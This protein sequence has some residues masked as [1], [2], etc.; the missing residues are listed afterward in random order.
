MCFVSWSARI[1]SCYLRYESRISIPICIPV[2]FPACGSQI[3]ETKLRLKE[4]RRSFF[5]VVWKSMTPSP[6]NV[7]LK[8]GLPTLTIRESFF[9]FYIFHIF[10]PEHACDCGSL[11]RIR[12][13]TNG[14]TITKS[15]TTAPPTPSLTFRGWVLTGERRPRQLEAG[16]FEPGELMTPDK[17]PLFDT[18]LWIRIRSERVHSLTQCCGSGSGTFCRIRIRI[19]NKLFRIRIRPIPNFSVKKSHFLNQMHKKSE[20]L[21][22]IYIVRPTRMC[23]KHPPTWA[24]V[25]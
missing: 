17:S 20:Y 22:H 12:T 13:E 3:Q 2:P 11:N 10:C 14:N 6:L 18:V 21:A 5:F 15:A 9:P 16:T 23:S 25:S 24:R 1:R 8:N 7:G 4:K 19:R